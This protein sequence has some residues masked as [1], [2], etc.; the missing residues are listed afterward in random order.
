MPYRW[1]CNA[2]P[3]IAQAGLKG[4]AIGLPELLMAPVE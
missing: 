3:L 4:R 1:G 2:H